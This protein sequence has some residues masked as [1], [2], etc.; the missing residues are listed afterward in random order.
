MVWEYRNNPDI[1]A[2]TGGNATRLPNG[3][4]IVRWGG[5]AKTGDAPAMTEAGPNGQLLYEI[6]PAHENV[7]GGFNRIIWPLDDLT[8]QVTHYELMPIMGEAPA[9]S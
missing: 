7:V 1:L 8:T 9:F 5:A 2:L 6:W 4:T 3:N